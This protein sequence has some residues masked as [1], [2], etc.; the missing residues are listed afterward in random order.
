MNSVKRKDTIENSQTAK[1]IKKECSYGDGCYRRNPAH[2]REF[3]HTHLE[4]ILD[5][6]DGEGTFPIP[7]KYNLQ[8]QMFREQLQV[9][10][11]KKLYEPKVKVGSSSETSI[12][13]E[14]TIVH[15]AQSNTEDTSMKSK[16]TASST[17]MIDKDNNPMSGS[18]SSRITILTQECSRSGNDGTSND[19]SQV[20][21]RD[22]NKLPTTSTDDYVNRPKDSEYRPIVQPKRRAEEYL[23]VVL[24]R[25]KMAAKHLASAPY[26]I[27]YTT[28]A[29]ARETHDQPY[30]IT[31]LEIL[32][33]SLGELKCSLQINFM[34]EIGWLL[35]QYYFA[36]Y[37][38]KRLT[39]LYGEDMEDLRT[40]NKKKPHVDAH[41]VSMPTPFGKHHTKMMILCYEDGSLRV[42]VSTAN[43]YVDDWENRTQGL[44]F[45]PACRELPSDAMPH[46][47][48]SPTMFKRSLLRYLNHYRLPSLSFYMERVKRCDFSHINKCVGIYWDFPVVFLRERRKTLSA[49]LFHLP[50]LVHVPEHFVVNKPPLL[51]TNI[52]HN[53][54]F[55]K[56]NKTAKV[57][58]PDPAKKS[59]G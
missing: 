20:K 7:E 24:P 39:I 56:K 37:S 17:N 52:R 50:T 22:K 35:A 29:D 48:E 59:W 49:I 15:T 38:E 21:E 12:C 43:L 4:D 6:Y 19:E 34:V 47:G 46:E 27:F 54:I 40:I 41:H 44:W 10:I 3:S 30:S 31:F 13:T 36:G 32:D 42:V 11:E 5:N 18:E 26:H 58:L 25:G 16:N 28:I 1:R 8:K 9:I 51:D 2:F 14:S 33:H 23:K 45:S 53:P 57:M 55:N